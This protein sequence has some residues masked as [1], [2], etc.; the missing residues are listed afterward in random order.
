MQSDIFLHNT[1]K[2]FFMS[3]FRKY[4][5]LPKENRRNFHCRQRLTKGSVVYYAPPLG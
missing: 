5:L 2:I 4:A 3:N 1:Y